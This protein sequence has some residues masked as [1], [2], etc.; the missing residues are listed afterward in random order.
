[1]EYE[2]Q[3]A[4]WLIFRVKPTLSAYIFSFFFCRFTKT[5]SKYEFMCTH[6]NDVACS[7]TYTN[8]PAA[9]PDDPLEEVLEL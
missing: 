4:K 8:P 7:A 3:G 9:L 5:Y 6:Y 2:S 1:M